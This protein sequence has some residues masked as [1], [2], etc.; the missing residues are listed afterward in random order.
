M[1]AVFGV[2][3]PADFLPVNL[4]SAMMFVNKRRARKSENFHNQDLRIAQIIPL[5]GGARGGLCGMALKRRLPHP[6]PLPR[7]EFAV[8][9]S[10]RLRKS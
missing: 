3:Y 6:L 8:D 10:N 1:T 2:L 7:G 4:L 5:L 9:L